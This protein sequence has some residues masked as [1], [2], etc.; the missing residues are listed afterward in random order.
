MKKIIFFIS[1]ITFWSNIISAITIDIIAPNYKNQSIIWKKK[2][3]YISNQY[4]II[5]QRTIDSTGKVK[6]VGDLIDNELTELSIGRSHGF[7]YVDTSTKNYSV[8]FPEDT[9]LESSSLQKSQIQLLFL[10]LAQDDINNLILSFNLHYDYFLYGDTNKLIRMARHDDEFQDSLNDFKIFVSKKYGP[11]KIKYLHNY[12]RYEIALLEQMAHQSKGDI[13]R[14]YLFN[15]YLKKNEIRYNNDAYMQFFNLFYFKTFRICGNEMYEKVLFTINQLQDFEKL[16]NIL[17]KNQYFEPNKLRE[18][19]IIKG[20]YDGFSSN[21]FSSKVVIDMLTH[22]TKTSLWKKHK[23]ISQKCIYELLKYEV[24]RKCPEFYLVNQNDEYL[25]VEDCQK[26]FTYINFFAT[27]NHKSLQE[28]EIINQMNT[29]YDF[30][31]FVSVNMDQEDVKYENYIKENKHFNWQICKPV[32]IEE[33]INTFDIDHL[34]TH[35]L[36]DPYGLIAQYPAYPPTPLYNNQS[37]DV[38]FFNIQKNNSTKSIFGI[39]GKN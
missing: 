28:M 11:N 23:L 19:A 31:N 30:I 36:I 18:L 15:T 38:T 39:G 4:L 16:N 10:D 3:D 7:I 13:Y 17:A 34:P 14:T 29:K 12:I 8:Y 32:N 35:L 33:I 9:L 2:T 20:L 22:I 1:L 25:N 37:I 26:N 24:G 5:D 6:L 21:E 27:W